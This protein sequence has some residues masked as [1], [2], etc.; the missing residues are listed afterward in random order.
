[1]VEGYYFISSASN[2]LCHVCLNSQV[3]SVNNIYSYFDH[4]C[5]I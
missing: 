1:M 4:Y 5:D 3:S 2:I